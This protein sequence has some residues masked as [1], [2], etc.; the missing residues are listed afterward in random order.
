MAGQADVLVSSSTP[1]SELDRR[2]FTHEMGHLFRLPD[3]Y[4]QEVFPSDN[5]VV[6]IGITPHVKDIM[7]SVL[8]YDHFAETSASFINLVDFIPPRS[9]FIPSE[10]AFT[11]KR[12]VLKITNDQGLP[13]KDVKVE[14]FPA[15]IEFNNIFN[16]FVNKIRNVVSFSGSTSDQGEFELGDLRKLFN[17]SGGFLN[18][19]SLLRLT[20]QDE[21]RYTAITN[22][23]LNTLYFQ[24][25]K[26]TATISLPFSTLFKPLATLLKEKD[27]LQ[28]LTIPGL[29]P[30]SQQ[31]PSE[32][33]KK[34]LKEH[35][36]RHIEKERKQNIRN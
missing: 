14:V 30:V 5:E 11:P 16:V 4:L 8:A 36:K 2:V 34:F 20:Y 18:R 25:E 28:M 32:Q 10:F 13:L 19:V 1:L 21:V 27:K 35:L 31:I 22:S 7:Y 26:E 12:I 33:E 29:P 9:I 17:H 3:Y 15:S 23:F 24:G 6:A